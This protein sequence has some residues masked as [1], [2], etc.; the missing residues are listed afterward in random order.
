MNLSTEGK[1]ISNVYNMYVKI[2][3]KVSGSNKQQATEHCG[4]GLLKAVGISAPRTVQLIQR[5]Y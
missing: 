4:H 2:H 3:S 1:S 5:K